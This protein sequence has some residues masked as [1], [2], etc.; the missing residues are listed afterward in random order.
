MAIVPPL[1][2]RVRDSS[3]EQIISE[4]LL[5]TGGISQ[6]IAARNDR[7]DQRGGT[8]AMNGDA[9]DYRI[10]ASRRSTDTEGIPE[11]EEE[12]VER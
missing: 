2:P 1:P 10:D 12:H 3:L 11:A 9:E 8:S 6:E 5:V 7:Q 4:A